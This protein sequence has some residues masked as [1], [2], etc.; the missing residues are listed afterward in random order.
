MKRAMKPWLSLLAAGVALA[1]ANTAQAE[2]RPHRAEYSLRLGTAANAP[3]IG[4]AIQ[5]LTLD[6]TGWH[7]RR[8]V[9]AE[10]AL[11]P[12]LKVKVTSQLTGEEDRAGNAFR[13]R[14]VI[15]QNGAERKTSGSVRR[16]GDAVRATVETPDGTNESI[17][18]P[19]TQMPVAVLGSLVA[20]LAAG[21][22]SFPLMMFAAEGAG[23]ALRLDVRPVGPEALPSTPPAEK[24]SVAPAARSWAVAMAVTRAATRAGTED[25][26]PATSVRAQV[27]ESGLLDRLVID[28]GIVTIAAYLHA[29]HMSEMPDCPGR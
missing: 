21:K 14:T 7:I 18:P 6:C 26:K 13:Y 15:V 25:Q 10:A 27:F 12:S 4:K 2:L 28:A 23:E 9:V 20:E 19:A 11:T 17:L 29:V 24:Q 16:E 5:E 3:R 22:S 8:E 1:L